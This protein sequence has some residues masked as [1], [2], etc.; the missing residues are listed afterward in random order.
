[1]NQRTF[2]R[3][4]EIIAALKVKTKNGKSHHGAIIYRKGK[5]L[6]I[7][8]NNYL[9]THN[10]NRFGKYKDHKGYATEYKACRHAEISSVIRYGEEDLSGCEMLVVRIDRFNKPS[11]S[12]CCPNCLG[13]LRGLNVKKV[14]YSNEQGNFQQ[15]ERF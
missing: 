10:S 4:V 5:I 2:N 6:A 12:K 8:V 11:L 14:F 3:A 9:K 13:V 15:D 7:G 1:M